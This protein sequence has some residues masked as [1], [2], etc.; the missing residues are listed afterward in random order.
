MSALYA[1]P[2]ICKPRLKS[3]RPP[4][5]I[6]KG[7]VTSSAV[8]TAST[9]TNRDESRPHARPSPDGAV[10]CSCILI[11]AICADLLRVRRHPRHQQPYRV[12]IRF[13]NRP[14]A[15]DLSCIHDDY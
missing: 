7:M 10:P 2:A 12:T 9:G 1:V 3:P 11:S 13:V 15:E 6:M 14:R 5:T 4:V 8:T